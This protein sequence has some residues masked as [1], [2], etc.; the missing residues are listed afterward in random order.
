MKTIWK[1]PLYQDMATTSAELP[2]G[3]IPVHVALQNDTLCIWCRVDT[4]QPRS[5]IMFEVIGT[6]HLEPRGKTYIGSVQQP[7]FVWHVYY[8]GP[9]DEV[10]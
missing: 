2:V 4:E 6:G 3:A 8:S 10:V 9:S 1:V 7:P 5:T